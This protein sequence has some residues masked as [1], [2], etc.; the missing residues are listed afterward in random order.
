MYMCTLQ[1]TQDEHTCTHRQL[2]YR[3]P[4]QRE[5]EEGGREVGREREEAQGDRWI[6]SQIMQPA[7]SVFD[8][9]T[10]PKLVCRLGR[11][12]TTSLMPAGADMLELSNSGPLPKGAGADSVGMETI[13]SDSTS[14]QSA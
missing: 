13:D 12:M 5:R 10:N 3:H 7:R 4:D 11:S 1:G 2:K 6:D 14:T 9:S 8:C